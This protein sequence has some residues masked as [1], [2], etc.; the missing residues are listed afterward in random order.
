MSDADKEKNS[1][2]ISEQKE[3]PGLMESYGSF[4]VW[5]LKLIDAIT[6]EFLISKEPVEKKK[7]PQ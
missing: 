7:L 2:D 3:E 4:P 5:S 1:S 6:P